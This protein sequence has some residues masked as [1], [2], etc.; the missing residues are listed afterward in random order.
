MSNPQQPRK[1]PRSPTPTSP[2]PTGAPPIFKKVQITEEKEENIEQEK[3]DIK[4][5]MI[6]TKEEET[7]SSTV[8][9]NGHA[10]PTQATGGGGSATPTP[11]PGTPS[12]PEL[13]PLPGVFDCP[14]CEAEDRNDCNCDEIV[15]S[16]LTHRNNSEQIV[17]YSEEDGIEF[18]LVENSSDE[19]TDG[20][21][22][23]VATPAAVSDYKC[24]F[25]FCGAKFATKNDLLSHRLSKHCKLQRTCPKCEG[26][27]SNDHDYNR[28]IKA[29]HREGTN[30]FFCDF[31]G[32]AFGRHS[33]LKRHYLTVHKKVPD[34][35]QHPDIQKQAF[36]EL[37]S[38]EEENVE[39]EKL[40]IIE[41]R[42]ETKEEEANV[43][44]AIEAPPTAPSASASSSPKP[45]V[46]TQ[47]A[48]GTASATPTP[49]PVPELIP[50]SA[51]S[52]PDITISLTD[53]RAQVRVDGTYVL[54]DN[55]HQETA[56]KVFFYVK[57]QTTPSAPSA[58]NAAIPTSTPSISEEVQIKEEII[59]SEPEKEESV[60]PEKAV[61]K[62]EISETT[63]EETSEIED[64]ELQQGLYLSYG[65]TAKKSHN[66][67]KWKKSQPKNANNDP[68]TST[69]SGNLLAF[70]EV[71]I[72]KEEPDKEEIVEPEKVEII[73][74]AIKDM[75]E[76][77]VQKPN[78]K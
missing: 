51:R 34:W 52:V 41:E 28:H 78:N 58:Y 37:E 25:H 17:F 43:E 54:M 45:A 50:N 29:A 53:T 71:L 15:L 63:D 30:N 13:I 64:S 74:S 55:Y 72:K 20:P 14:R 9:A 36:E 21:S 6:E 1:R 10:M 44:V 60:E 67:S 61:I 33:H 75:E 40:E 49:T 32:K 42:T 48:G 62:E 66:R 27:F 38:E 59:E 77:V 4:E 16:S 57:S 65:S 69:N 7:T 19:P 73:D 11:K 39:L 31:C 18:I 47:A 24:D 56:A 76:D 2:T 26:L 12:M 22:T 46:P 8:P 23:P 3:I 5:E 35:M 68:Q 70:E